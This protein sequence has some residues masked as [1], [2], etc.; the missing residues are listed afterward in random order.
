MVAAVAVDP[1]DVVKGIGRSAH[2]PSSPPLLLSRPVGSSGPTPAVR[3]SDT[4]SAIHRQWA[5]LGSGPDRST[6]AS[7]A[8]RVARKAR[9]RLGGLSRR[10]AVPGRS[11]ETELLGSLVRAADT[12][13]VRSD[14]LAS[15]LDNLEAALEEVV[16]A[17]SEDLVRIR[18]A[19]AD[20]QD[21]AAGDS[22]G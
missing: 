6:A 3:G 10:L 14:E 1:S 15:R 2:V 9:A 8:K 18:A 12:L 16:Q 4:I 17:V 19:L 7:T 22:D 5:A 20:R 21:R 11:D 13:A